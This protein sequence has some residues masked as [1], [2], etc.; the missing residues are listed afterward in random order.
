MCGYRYFSTRRV[1]LTERHGF[2]CSRAAENKKVRQAVSLELSF[3]NSNLEFLKEELSDLNS[4]VD[5]YQN[6]DRYAQVSLVLIIPPSIE[7]AFRCGGW[8]LGRAPNP[9]AEFHRSKC[10]IQ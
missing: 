2:D 8:A 9:V 10:T 3:L 1:W 5:I 7:T 4:S 6:D